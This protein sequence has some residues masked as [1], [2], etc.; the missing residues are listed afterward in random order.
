MKILIFSNRRNKCVVISVTEG[1]LS[2][3]RKGEISESVTEK[4]IGPRRY[5]SAHGRKSLQS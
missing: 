5:P 2:V 4:G 3:G 1:N